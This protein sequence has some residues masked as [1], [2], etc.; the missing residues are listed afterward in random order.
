MRRASLAIIGADL[1]AASK[2][3]ESMGFATLDGK[4]DK[5]QAEIATDE[6]NYR[7]Y[8]GCQEYLERY[9]AWFEIMHPGEEFLPFQIGARMALETSSPQ[10]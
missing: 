3:D 9:E 1:E 6:L 8:E 2:F 7:Q 5:L 4:A 10:F